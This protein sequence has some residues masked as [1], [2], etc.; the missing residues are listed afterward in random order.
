MGQRNNIVNVSE[1]TR[2]LSDGASSTT[3]LESSDTGDLQKMLSISCPTANQLFF[4]DANPTIQAYYRFT[5]TSDHPFAVLYTRPQDGPM[6]L[7]S[8]TTPSS[9]QFSQK[10]DTSSMASNSTSSNTNVTGL[11]RRSAVLPSHGTDPSGTWI[12]VSVGGRSGWARKH[13]FHKTSDNK[14]RTSST[15]NSHVPTFTLANTF[16]ATEGWMGNQVFLMNGKIML[17][18]D[19]PLFFFTNVVIG[20]AIVIHFFV[21]LPHL[22]KNESLLKVSDSASIFQWTTHS[23]TV[24]LT[25]VLTFMSFLTMWVSATTDP[26]ILPPISSPV[27]APIPN[28]GKTSI[29]GPLGYR[30]CSTCN[31]FRPPRSKHCNSC[32][33][34]VAKF[35]HHC[36]WVGN[37]IGARNHKW[38]FSFL[39]SISLLTI[40]T[41]ATCVRVFLQTFQCIAQNSTAKNNSFSHILYECITSEPVVILMACFTLLCGW[42]LSSLTCYHAYIISLAQTT[43]EKVRGVYDHHLKN[44]KDSGC[45]KNWND[46][47]CEKVPESLILH[48]FSE[49]VDC[50]AARRERTERKKARRSI[51]SED[52]SRYSDLNFEVETVYEPVKA[53]EAVKEAIV[54]GI[55]YRAT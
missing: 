6:A 16:R 11:L 36:P 17:G 2:L 23:L 40:I 50:C 46:V 51:I 45:L 3:V 39:V 52:G 15:Q 32:N 43:N 8:E 22:Y 54:N 20:V 18:S 49:T 37:C 42:S 31:I 14:S 4:P 55:L 41:T 38:F 27:K 10:N 12:L 5:V 28:D 13:Q 24:W 7:V 1:K 44:P 33:V 30:Y 47:F 35:D 34:C 21:V 29:G 53:N 26:G 19:A 25:I 48:K 9:D